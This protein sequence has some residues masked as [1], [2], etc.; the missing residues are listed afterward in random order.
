MN[1]VKFEVPKLKRLNTP[2]SA[3]DDGP[4]RQLQIERRFML[5]RAAD[6]GA[7]TLRQYVSRRRSEIGANS[8]VRYS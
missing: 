7:S 2:D 1:T 4:L 6:I 8:L 5:R 3:V